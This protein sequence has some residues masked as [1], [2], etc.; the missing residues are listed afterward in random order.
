MR[1]GLIGYGKMGQLIDILAPKQGHVVT[2]RFSRHKGSL[3]EQQ[4]SLTSVDIAIDFSH[5]SL[6]SEH[7][8]LCLIHR[9][10][11]V[12]GTTGW[13]EIQPTIREQV[14]NSEGSCLYSPN[15]SLGLYLFN[16]I[17]AHAATLLESHAHYDTA[18]VEQHHRQKRDA[19]SGT[20]LRL[21]DTLTRHMPRSHPIPCSSLRCGEIPGTH[22]VLF[23]SLPDS[24]TLTHT[25]RTR[26]GFAI[27]AIQGAEWLIS[28]RGFFTMDDFMAG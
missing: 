28:R 23:D 16:Q 10:P 14:Q 9:I 11:L 20:A 12:I 2:A 27:G 21:M 19:P 3:R 6:V 17:V 18:L 26:E 5:P 22:T 24:I 4:H 8:S 7:V 25:A 13:D 1:I 15:F